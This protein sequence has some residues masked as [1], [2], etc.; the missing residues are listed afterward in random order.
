[1]FGFL[2]ICSIVLFI[3]I[4]VGAVIINEELGGSEAS[5]YLILGL[6]SAIFLCAYFYYLGQES[7]QYD[8]YIDLKSNDL[9]EWVEITTDE[10]SVYQIHP[11]SL[12]EFI[13]KDNL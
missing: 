10:D 5:V 6:G 1:M 2:I 9:H 13:I 4:V 11:D 7:M 12:E 3:T 8:Y